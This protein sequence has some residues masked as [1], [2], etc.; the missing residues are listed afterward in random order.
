M[1][2]NGLPVTPVARTLRD[3]A[4]LL[5]LKR[6]RKALADAD[7]RRLL[8]P[9]SLL[10]E[11]GRGK[12]GAALLRKAWSIHRPDLARTRSPL[13]VEFAL[14]C[15]RYAIPAPEVNVMVNGMEVDALW[16]DAGLAVELDGGQAH[17]TPAAVI[18]DRDRELRLRRAGLRTVRYSRVQIGMQAAAVAADLRTQLGLAQPSAN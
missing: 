10:K 7:Y 16:R 6:L 2:V 15:E 4:P 5:G 17:G 14:L 13:E 11:L 1:V 3:A 18:V 12:K 9:A 8:E